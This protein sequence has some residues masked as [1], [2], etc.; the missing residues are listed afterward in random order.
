MG[1]SEKCN[2]TDV[3]QKIFWTKW[4]EG[5]KRDR[6]RCAGIS[7]SSA[8]GKVR[9][10]TIHPVNYLHSEAFAE[11]SLTLKEAFLDLGV[12]AGLSRNVFSP[13]CINLILGWHLLDEA[14]EASLSVT[15]IIYNLEQMDER[16]R[17]LVTRLIRLSKRCQ[18]WDYSRRNIDILHQAGIRTPIHHVPIGTMPALTRIQPAK[19]QDIDVL[20]YG[21]LNPRRKKVLEALV[22]EGVRVR[23][24]FGVYGDERDSL[25]AR[26]KI[27]LNL[28]YYETSI[29][30]MVRLSYLW[31]NGKAVVAEFNDAT[32]IPDA[33]EGAACFV[34]YEKLVNACITLLADENARKDLERRSFEAMTAHR[35]TEILKRIPGW[36]NES[37]CRRE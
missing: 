16:N 33:L 31:S 34:P 5:V 20:F 1:I 8:L 3:I 17:H 10:V 2:A 23:A 30:E 37:V 32:E 7:V 9:I 36:P 14:H 19:H 24:A 29:L 11:L 13:G 26:S 12:K 22:G 21:S 35:Q 4:S 18:L 28:H 15:S 25:I 6:E 27:V